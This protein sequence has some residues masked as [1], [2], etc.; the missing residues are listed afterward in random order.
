LYIKLPS[1][2]LAKANRLSVYD[3]NGRISFEKSDIHVGA[4]ELHSILLS[5]RNGVYI[6]KMTV[7]G[8]VY[9]SKILVF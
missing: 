2:G 8:K 6:V 9:T 3:L 1:D 7:N 4:G 5:V